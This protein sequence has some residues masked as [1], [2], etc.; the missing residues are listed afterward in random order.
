MTLNASLSNWIDAQRRSYV[1]TTPIS[2]RFLSPTHLVERHAPGGR[3]RRYSQ[4]ARSHGTNGSAAIRRSSHSNGLSGKWQSGLLHAV[5]ATKLIEGLQELS[6][7]E[8]DIRFAGLDARRLRP[9]INANYSIPWN[10]LYNRHEHGFDV[11]DNMARGTENFIRDVQA[12]LAELPAGTDSVFIGHSFGGDF[13]LSFLQVWRRT[14]HP[15]LFAGVIDPVDGAGLEIRCEARR[16]VTMSS[17]STIGGKQ[18]SR[19]Q[20]M[21]LAQ[22]P[23]DAAPIS[24]TRLK[25]ASIGTGTEAMSGYNVA[26]WKLAVM[27]LTQP[28]R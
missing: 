24:A 13:I 20:S 8:V 4:A 7:T 22:V 19:G 28:G 1:S 10:S 9:N 27:A 3:S 14:K 15:I 21:F 11:G 6:G 16:L 26:N 23:S 12:Y 18:M 5:K 17:I 2:D 25:T